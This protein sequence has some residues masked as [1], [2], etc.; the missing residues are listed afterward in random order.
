VH[1]KTSPVVTADAMGKGR[2]VI[3]TIQKI[4]PAP[5]AKHPNKNQREKRVFKKES[6]TSVNKAKFSPI[7]AIFQDI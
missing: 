4:T 1:I 3:N 6:L 2:R 5:Y 7:V